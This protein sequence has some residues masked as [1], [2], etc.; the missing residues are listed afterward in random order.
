MLRKEAVTS[1]TLE[2]LKELMQEELLKNFILVGG[3]AL[4][5]LIGHRISI[6]LD[7]FSTNPFD[8]Q[9]LF[10]YLEQNKNFKLDSLQKNTIKGQIG[11][12]K[13]D[14]ITHAYPFVKTALLIEGIRMA[15]L[16]D[17]IAMKLNAIAGNGTRLKDFI[18]IFYLSSLFSLNQMTE[19]YSV[20]YDSR[21]SFIPLKALAYFNDINFQEPVQMLTGKLPW[22]S[23][24]KRINEMIN[25]PDR[26]FTTDGGN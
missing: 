11:E 26:I 3:T 24:E 16:E 19:A 14:L 13:I 4:S 20:K 6:D 17:I 25:N 22:Q 2:L 7:L 21:N 1:G 8:E 15:S 5:L 9:E 12:I 18:D 10:E 23:I